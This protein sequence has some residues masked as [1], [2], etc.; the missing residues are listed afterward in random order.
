MKKTTLKNRMKKNELYVVYTDADRTTLEQRWLTYG[1]G[2]PRIYAKNAVDDRILDDTPVCTTWESA[3]QRLW[4][5]KGPV[6]VPVSLLFE[7]AARIRRWAESQREVEPQ[8]VI[9]YAN[10]I[11]PPD[12]P[13]S[14]EV[15]FAKKNVTFENRFWI[16]DHPRGTLC[17]LLSWLESVRNECDF[18]NEEDVIADHVG[19][20]SGEAHA[21][22]SS[23]GD[24]TEPDD[25]DPATFGYRRDNLDEDIQSVE[26]LY[27]ALGGDVV[28]AELSPE[29]AIAG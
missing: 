21:Y 27:D 4:S 6:M 19:D 28:V 24:L 9:E 25:N 5:G 17:D 8:V 3:Y 26:L 1:D 11:C 23:W 20:L 10:R 13:D 12:A 7:S 15:L 18:F 22:F 16:K 2:T 29:L 14:K